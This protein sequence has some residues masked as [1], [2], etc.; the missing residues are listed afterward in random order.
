MPSDIFENLNTAWM[1]SIHPMVELSCCS[2]YR[3]ELYRMCLHEILITYFYYY[4]VIFFYS[5]M[6]IFSNAEK[7]ENENV[8]EQQFSSHATD[9]QMDLSVAFNLPI[10]KH[11]PY[12]TSHFFVVF[13]LCFDSLSCGMSGWLEQVL[14]NNLLV[15]CIIHVA[16]NGNSI[17]GYKPV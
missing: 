12:F 14:I 8:G 11:K 6:Q 13:A 3:F 7:L 5:S 15:F 2:D 1:N 4:F 10:P 17:S 9:F 16:W